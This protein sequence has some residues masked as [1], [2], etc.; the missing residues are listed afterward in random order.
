MLSLQVVKGAA[1]VLITGLLCA[2][3]ALPSHHAPESAV[4]LLENPGQQPVAADPA[5]R[6]KPLQELMRRG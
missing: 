3:L 1:V 2:G 6:T 5:Q 4:P